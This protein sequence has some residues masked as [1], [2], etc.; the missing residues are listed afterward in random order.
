M[1]AELGGRDKGLFRLP[2]SEVPTSES[3][4][5][6]V[7]DSVSQLCSSKLALLRGWLDTDTDYK[8]FRSLLFEG[9]SSETYPPLCSLSCG[10]SVRFWGAVVGSGRGLGRM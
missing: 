9:S 4:M 8:S 1:S 5:L 10:G 7:P 6:N 2:L 3:I